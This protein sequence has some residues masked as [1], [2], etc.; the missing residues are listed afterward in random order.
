MAVIDWLN[1]NSGAIIGIAAVALIG[2]TRL[3]CLFNAS[4]PKSR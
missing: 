1:A 3:L 2:I 4:A